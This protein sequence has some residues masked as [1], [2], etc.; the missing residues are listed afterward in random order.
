MKKILI[1]PLVIFSC[2]LLKNNVYASGACADHGG[3]NCSAGMTSTGGV[4]CNDGWTGSSVAYTDM[5]EC[6]DNITC[7][8]D[9]YDSLLHKDGVTT[10]QSKE[11]SDMQQIQAINNQIDSLNN[12]I[13]STEQ[14]KR[15]EIAQSGGVVDESQLESMVLSE[16][17]SLIQQQNE[18]TGKLN[19]LNE[20]ESQTQDDINLFTS[21]AKEECHNLGRTKILNQTEEII[22]NQNNQPQ[23]TSLPRNNTTSQPMISSPVSANSVSDKSLS[24]LSSSEFKLVGNELLHSCPDTTCS[25]IQY[26]TM[27]GVA[28][29]LYVQNGW[30]KVEVTEYGY[31]DNT[32]NSEGKL[33]TP[34]TTTGWLKTSLV[35][36]SVV[37]PSNPTPS[38]ATD[39]SITPISTTTP[40]TVYNQ[41]HWYDW[42]NP[43][44][45][46]KL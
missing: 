4:I 1:I 39:T 30:D 40:N 9:E 42:L 44:T 14:N 7:T 46:F 21:Q 24:N 23:T 19:L 26:G 6:M 15:N 25:I 33:K 32:S 16:N 41:K 31:F 8:T 28:K 11:Q 10:A 18:L 45:W 22:N 13:A 5:N 12:Q 17:Q 43:F 2:F 37:I 38:V 36:K 3:V 34:V 35:P 20:D 27:D 29:V